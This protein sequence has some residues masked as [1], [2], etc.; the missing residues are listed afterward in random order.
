M[1]REAVHAV[2]GD[3][4]PSGRK[5]KCVRQCAYTVSPERV[6]SFHQSLRV[7]RESKRLKNTSLEILFLLH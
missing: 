7:F 5:R 3:L 4:Q 6:H 1:R 2:S